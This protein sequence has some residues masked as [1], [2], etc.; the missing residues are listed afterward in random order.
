MAKP[1]QIPGPAAEAWTT[2]WLDSAAAGSRSMSQRSVASVDA[3]GGG[4]A[5]ARSLARE[6]GLHLV[7]FVDGRGN[8]LVAAS[9]NPFRIVC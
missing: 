4:L 5:F 2:R 9:K 6:R 7:L 8:R 1:K 3:W